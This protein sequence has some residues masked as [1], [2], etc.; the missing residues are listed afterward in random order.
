MHFAVEL[1]S[2]YWVKCLTTLAVMAQAG[3]KSDYENQSFHSRTAREPVPGRVSRSG[4]SH[5]T[6][7][8]SRA[9]GG[10][11]LSPEL[12]WDGPSE[13]TGRAAA[14]SRQSSLLTFFSKPA[15][16]NDDG[17]SGSSTSD[18][19][20]R[21]Q[22]SASAS[23]SSQG[24]TPALP[25][26]CD[27]SD[28]SP[29]DLV[30]AKLEGYPWWPCLVYAHPTEGSLF[31]GRGRAS[32]IHVQFFEDDPSRGW[33][34]I[35]YIR[36]YKGS[37]GRD[38]QR[39]GMFYSSRPEIK[40]AMELADVALR[41]DKSE[42]L[43]LAICDKPSESEGEEEEEETE[44]SDEGDDFDTVKEIKTRNKR[45]ARRKLSDGKAK[46]RKIFMDSDTDNE[47]SD[48]EFQPDEGK[49]RYQMEI[50]ETAVPRDLPDEYIMKSSRK[51]YKRFWTKDIEKML[52]EIINAEERRDAAQKDCM[53]RL[54][55]DFDKTRKDW[56][57]AVECIAVLD[58]LLCL[59]RYS[60]G[61][62]GPLCRP[63]ILLP[64]NI[65][66]F[67][68][69]KSS[70]HPCIT[71]I[72]FGDD[73]IPNDI[74]IGLED[75]KTNSRATCVLVTGPNMGGKSTLMRQAGLLVIMAQLGCFV[76]AESCR[77]TP[78]DRVFT[79]LG[80]SD[81]IMSGES[82]FFVEL[83]ETSSI[84]QHATEHSLVL[85][86]ELG[87]GTATF[88]GTAIASAVVKELSEN[89]KCR[90]MFS[91]H[92][93]SLVEDYSHSLSVQLGHMACMVENECED[94]SQETITF[95]YKFVNG[96]CPKSYGFNAARL[97]DIPEEVIQKGHK[98]A[99]EFE[100]AVLS[101]KVFR[102]LCWIAE[103][104]LAARDYL[105]KQT[106]LHV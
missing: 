104:A 86:D 27:F 69:L 49:N 53:K 13:L 16:K 6:E 91:T 21:L 90:T 83:S 101:M 54:F 9:K 94:P 93:H 82:T 26:D 77:L 61:C 28:F 105:D 95:L 24:R 15:E 74:V 58:V 14:M 76:P 25:A 38:T 102:N 46:K 45:I 68:E 42:R 64:E 41:K 78:V 22:V 50:A 5:S 98:K 39:G 85:M 80:A 40:R 57:T 56:Q 72:F 89:I 99:K 97:A 12:R 20:G 73:F 10:F 34:S 106:L 8:P 35:R 48:M 30:W 79:R 33:V 84:L 66:P 71:K 37:T 19:E 31:R 47:G 17:G 87:R 96:A 4:C 11:F 29:G 52:N 63:E 1:F 18:A 51:G 32:R 2:C 60:Q 92:Y 3:G 55:Y 67:V 44:V 43:G 70:R 62:D 88:D 100:K 81:R 59:A 36:P 65:P 23:S 75:K 103:G 7:L